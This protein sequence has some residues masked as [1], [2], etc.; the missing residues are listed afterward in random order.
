MRRI[1]LHDA[2]VSILSASMV[3][4]LLVDMSDL[5]PDVGVGEGIGRV[6]EYAVEAF[7]GLGVLGLLLVDDAQTEQ[8][9][10]R[11]VKFDD[12]NRSVK[13]PK[14]KQVYSPLSI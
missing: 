14:C 12:C 6:A 1:L 5:D 3:L 4:H 10:V 7:K 11:F 2:L 9:L 8:D 13:V